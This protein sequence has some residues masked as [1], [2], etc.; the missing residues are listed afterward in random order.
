MKHHL[1]VSIAGILRPFQPADRQRSSARADNSRG[2]RSLRHTTTSGSSGSARLYAS[3]EPSTRLAC[4]PVASAT[5]TGA[6][7]SHSYWPPACTY[8]STSPRM[9]AAILAPAEPIGTRSAPSRSA[10]ASR[11]AGGRDRLPARRRPAPA[12]AAPGHG[13]GAGGG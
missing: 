9:T 12:A 7:E 1:I 11:K 10:S 13:G 5:A 2:A 3:G 4:R 6:A 8:P